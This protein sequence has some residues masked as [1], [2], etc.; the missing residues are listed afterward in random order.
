MSQLRLPG[1]LVVTDT[2]LA[3]HILRRSWGAVR[4]EG[5]DAD[6][7][8]LARGCD[9]TGRVLPDVDLVALDARDWPEI[10]QTVERR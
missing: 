1:S 6:G 4:V 8:V 2:R 10:A 9:G 7:R 5:R 3:G